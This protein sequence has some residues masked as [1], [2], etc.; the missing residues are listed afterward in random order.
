MRAGATHPKPLVATRRFTFH[1]TV[2]VVVGRLLLLAVSANLFV[3]AKLLARGG[4]RVC[5]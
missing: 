3:C 4:A 5:P 2:P 1:G